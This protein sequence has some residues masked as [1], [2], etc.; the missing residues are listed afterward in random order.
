MDIGFWASRVQSSKYLSTMQTSRLNSE[1]DEDVRTCFPCPFCYV[2]IEI[3]VLCAHLTEEHCFD[4]KNAV[5]PVCAENLGKDLIGHF[6]VHHAHMLKRRK[7]Q[8]IGLN[9]NGSAP[10]GKEL[11][12]LSSFIGIVTSNHKG[13]AFDSAP[14]P[15]LSPFL[16]SLTLPDTRGDQGARSYNDV[17]VLSSSECANSKEQFKTMEVRYE[18]YRERSQRANF[19]QQLIFSTIF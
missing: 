12:E 16:C 3:P 5:C 6:T 2:E 7:S 18:A 8:R 19:F 11:Q 1:E 9:I 14:D 10:L 15:L 4:V 17:Q 13:N